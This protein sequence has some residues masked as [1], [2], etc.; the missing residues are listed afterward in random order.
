MSPVFFLIAIAC[1]LFRPP[2]SGPLILAPLFWLPSCTGRRCATMAKCNNAHA[3][4]AHMADDAR[5]V[6]SMAV[7]HHPKPCS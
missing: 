6:N 4:G 5:A 1:A 3:S 2:N 7:M